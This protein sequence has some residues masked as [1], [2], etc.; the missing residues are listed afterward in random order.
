MRCR[1]RPF[2]IASRL[3][4][5]AAAAGAAAQQ[6]ALMQRR[7]K[8]MQSRPVRRMRQK[9]ATQR[10]CAQ[11][12]YRTLQWCSARTAWP[13]SRTCCAGE[14]PS[15]R[16]KVSTAITAL[17]ARAAPL[18][19]KLWTTSST[20]F[21]NLTAVGA[22]QCGREPGR[23]HPLPAGAQAGGGGLL[24]RP[25]GAAAPAPWRRV[26]CCKQCLPLQRTVTPMQRGHL[27]TIEVEASGQAC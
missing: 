20:T 1:W 4:S 14:R 6:R 17:A 7:W 27:T 9:A 16:R 2:C 11:T 12:P 3:L 24:R 21:T 19:S 25:V 15:S 23:G 5:S 18:C 26:S 8:R 22:L 13:M 10:S